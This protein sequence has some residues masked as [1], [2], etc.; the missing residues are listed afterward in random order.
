MV[1]KM[2]GGPS[3]KNVWLGGSLKANNGLSGCQELATV[4]VKII[5]GPSVKSAWLRGSLKANNGP[6]GCHDV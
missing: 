6:I 1:V 4:V 2:I 5:G 3:V